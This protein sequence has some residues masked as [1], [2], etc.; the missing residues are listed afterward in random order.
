MTLSRAQLPLE[1]PPPRR[2]SGILGTFAFA[3]FRL[4]WGGLLISNLG[5]WT[6]FTALG[7]FVVQL[8]GTASLA[9]LYVGVLGASNA[10]PALLLSPV[11]GVVADRYPRR[12]GSGGA[13]DHATCGAMGTSPGGIG[14][15]VRAAISM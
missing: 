6:Q 3:D 12:R 14:R 13:A 10:V 15:L 4:L 11:A 7:Y 8:A 2:R 9:S 1:A 5:T